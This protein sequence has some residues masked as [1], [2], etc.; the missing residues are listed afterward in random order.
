[1][2]FGRDCHTIDVQNEPK[3]L[4]LIENPRKGER[5]GTFVKQRTSQLRQ[6]SPGVS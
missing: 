6:H 4:I 2:H 1:M 3:F 5:A